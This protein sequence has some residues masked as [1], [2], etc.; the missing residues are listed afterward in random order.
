MKTNRF[1]KRANCKSGK[2][3]HRFMMLYAATELATG[4]KITERAEDENVTMKFGADD[5]LLKGHI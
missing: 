5:L 1:S 4:G 2:T 3:E